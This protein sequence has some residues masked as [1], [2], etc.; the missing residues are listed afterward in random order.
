MKEKPQTAIIVGLLLHFILQHGIGSGGRERKN[1][2]W[3]AWQL[4]AVFAP[5]FNDGN[6]AGTAPDELAGLGAFGRI[7]N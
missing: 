6:I 7:D 1:Q 4:N 5:V 3:I 2:G